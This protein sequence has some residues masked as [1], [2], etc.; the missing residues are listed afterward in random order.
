MY[1]LLA[2]IIFTSYYTVHKVFGCENMKKIV[3]IGS[4]GAGKSTL[5][6]EL[7]DI[8]KIEVIHLDRYFWEPAWK[9]KP[10]ENRRQ[11]LRELV[12]KDHWIIEGTYLDTSDIRLNAADTVIFL[13]MPNWLCFWRVLNRYFKYHRKPR[14]DLPE[15]CR[16]RLRVHYLLKILGFPLV[17]RRGLYEWLSEFECEKSVYA[18][19]SSHKVKEF[20]W[21]LEQG[22]TL[23]E[24][25]LGNVPMVR[26][27]SLD[28]VM[29]LIGFFIKPT[30]R[31][32][33][34]LSKV[35]VRTSAV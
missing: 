8:L 13:D 14:V 1:S 11:I 25:A 7:G 32:I 3:I 19:Y 24:Y 29:V 35:K 12:Q 23:E 31:V 18:L 5:A 17:K 15:G 26:M 33:Y 4:P 6:R 9:E 20:L 28:L 22:L 16:E 10:R 27:K 2:L 34:N 30:W 21:K